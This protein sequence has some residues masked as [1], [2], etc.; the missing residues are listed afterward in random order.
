VAQPWHGWVGDPLFL[1][2]H[3]LFTV[4]GTG[5]VQ[6]PSLLGQVPPGESREGMQMYP[7]PGLS[8]KGLSSTVDDTGRV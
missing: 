6:L 3:A 1:H 5:L 8:P 2:S 7:S 4:W